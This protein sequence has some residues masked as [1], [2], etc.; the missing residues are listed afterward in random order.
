VKRLRHLV[1]LAAL[2]PALFLVDLMPL[3]LA[4]RTAALFA[5]I[6][7]FLSR[8]R[9]E[10]AC[11]NILKAGIATHP[12]EARRIARR[13]FQHF[14]ILVVEAIKAD[15]YL[16]ASN[17]RDALLPTIDPAAD[18][19]LEDPNQ[20]IILVSAHIGNWEIAAQMLSYIKP[21]VAIARK[22]NNPYVDRLMDRRKGKTRL[23]V[24]PKHDADA[25]RFF[26]TLKEGNCLAILIDQH[27]REGGMMIDFLGR[28]ASTHTSAAMLHLVTKA[29]ICF[30]S[31]I[32]T[33]PMQF[34]LTVDPPLQHTPTGDRKA[35]VE[36][37]LRK[38]TGRLEEI[39]RAHPEQYLW[40][41]RRWR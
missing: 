29:P 11:E 38:L 13:S 19:L 23:G 10:I 1:E 25:G 2:I 16:D 24:T 5:D 18:A 15:R 41:H 8:K 31:C 9:R 7:F 20:G 32:R 21:L 33:G 35:D 14:A 36:A 37:I 4:G 27:A 17:W 39:I 28:P 34:S 3:T 6:A 26:R 30:A 22:M 40:A 12:D